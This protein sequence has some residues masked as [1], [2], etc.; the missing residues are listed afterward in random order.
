MEKFKIKVR[1]LNGENVVFEGLLYDWFIL[2]EG[3]ETSN[4]LEV[5]HLCLP[6][7]NNET[8][9]VTQEDCTGNWIIEKI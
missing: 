8:N 1:V 4:I 6:L 2:Q 7:I 3:G 5:V 9:I